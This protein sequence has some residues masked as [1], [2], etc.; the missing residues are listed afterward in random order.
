MLRIQINFTFNS[1]LFLYNTH[2]KLKSSVVMYLLLGCLL[3]GTWYL[4]KNKEVLVTTA[5]EL[6]H[7]EHIYL[8]AGEKYDPG[9][10]PETKELTIADENIITLT[11]DNTFIGKAAGTTQVTLGCDTYEF[12]VSDL[13]TT[14]IL[15]MNKP[16]LPENAYTVAENRYLDQILEMLIEEAGYH[17]RAGAVEAVRFLTLRFPYKLHYFYENGRIGE[18]VYLADGEGRYYHKGLYLSDAKQQELS[19]ITTSTGCWGTPVFEDY[20]GEITP[21]GLD[22]SGFITWALYNAGYDCGDIGAGPTEDAYDLTDLGE[23][24]YWDELDMSKIRVGD[25]TGLDG[26]IGMIIG[27][28]DDKIYIGESYWVNDLQVRVYSYDE[29]V[30]E[31][32]WEYVILMEDYYKE[33]GNYTQFWE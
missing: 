11:E 29:F 2:M 7:F 12:E 17:T 25:L 14:Q 3:T 10:D 32:E 1:Y 9:Y 18:D 30:N 5:C 31:S 13:Y 28:K 21:N 23:M 19:D 20:T 33:D 16:Y 4:A 27:M 26:H 6:N 8:G 24:V 22:C 15:D